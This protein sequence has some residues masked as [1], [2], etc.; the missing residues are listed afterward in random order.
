MKTK[1]VWVWSFKDGNDEKIRVIY[2]HM[3]RDFWIDSIPKTVE[4]YMK[5]AQ[6]TTAKTVHGPTVFYKIFPYMQNN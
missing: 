3:I 1:I 2:D 6:R 5:K 4:N